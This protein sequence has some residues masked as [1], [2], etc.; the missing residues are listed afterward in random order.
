MENKEEVQKPEETKQI[1]VEEPPK[2]DN[3]DDDE[4][5]LEDK[6]ATK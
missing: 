3:S 5:S 2:E 6:V 4:K 1:P